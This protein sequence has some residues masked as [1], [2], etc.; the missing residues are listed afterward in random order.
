MLDHLKSYTSM[1][2]ITQLLMSFLAMILVAK[3]N[4]L[5]SVPPGSSM[6]PQIKA[7]MDWCGNFTGHVNTV[8]GK[9]ESARLEFDRR[10]L[11]IY[12]LLFDELTPG[13]T[14]PQGK[15]LEKCI[16]TNRAMLESIIVNIR[17]A[18]LY[19][20]GSILLPPFTTTSTQLRYE[21]LAGDMGSL[22]AQFRG[23]AI[24]IG[25][26]YVTQIISPVIK[27]K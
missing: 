6:D 26:L 2:R 15:L 7:V 19:L 9:L 25:N 5:S 18:E 13:A 16:K 27:V 11:S 12:A 3:G 21:D 8:M 4:C 23:L 1:V 24:L 10:D 22:K 17:L 14:H 20:D